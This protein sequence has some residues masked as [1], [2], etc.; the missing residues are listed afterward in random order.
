[1]KLNW[2]IVIIPLLVSSY[3]AAEE[4]KDVSA[5]D[6]KKMIDNDEKVFIVDARGE[7]GYKQGH[8]PT[9]VNITSD[10]FPSIKDSLPKD[11]DTMLIFYCT[12]GKAG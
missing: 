8:I 2:I 5:D 3:A 9:A 12:G 6:L 4:F 7:V 1:M 11:K 10:K